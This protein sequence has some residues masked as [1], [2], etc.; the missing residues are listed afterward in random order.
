MKISVTL[1]NRIIIMAIVSIILIGVIPY[2]SFYLL[3]KHI[4]T[5]AVIT[6]NKHGDIA[7]SLFMTEFLDNPQNTEGF[8]Y[9]G[10]IDLGNQIELDLS[11]SIKKS[12]EPY[13]S[14]WLLDASGKSLIKMVANLARSVFTAYAKN[15]IISSILSILGLLFVFILGKELLK[16]PN[17]EKDDE[18]TPTI[19][20]KF[21]VIY[22][23]ILSIFIVASG[24]YLLIYLIKNLITF[25]KYPPILRYPPVNA[26]SSFIFEAIVIVTGIA[27]LISILLLIIRKNNN[28]SKK[29]LAF[30]WTVPVLAII[31]NLY[32]GNRQILILNN[33]IDGQNLNAYR[34]KAI[35]HSAEIAYTARQWFLQNES[36]YSLEDFLKQDHL[37]THD[38]DYG[39]Y[40]I[41]ADDTLL[42]ITGAGN[43]VSKEGIS[44]KVTATYNTVTDSVDVDILQ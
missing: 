2:L 44:P 41:S 3:E 26:T 1:I 39:T 14:S 21:Q 20:S 30:F 42:T 11:D 25:I 37:K 16:K 38:L 32:M 34:Q 10:L 29:Y 9:E 35:N 18:T 17:M 4:V 6:F 40:E 5:E 28:Q 33:M 23:L 27:I 15:R 22:R 8:D 13:G 36:K 19:L 12:K 7:D 24:C 31:F 43:F